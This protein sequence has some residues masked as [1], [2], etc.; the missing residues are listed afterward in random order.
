MSRKKSSEKHNIAFFTSSVYDQQYDINGDIVIIRSDFKTAK[1]KISS[2]KKHGYSVHFSVNL[3]WGDFSEYLNGKW[4]DINHWEDVQCDRFGKYVFHGPNIPYIIPTVSFNNYILSKLIPVLEYGVEAIHIEEPYFFVKSGY[5]PSFKKEWEM[6]FQKP[7]TP[8][9]N[10]INAQYE[11][12]IL[13]GELVYRSI[14]FLSMELKSYCKYHFNRD[15]KIYVQTRGYISNIQN[16]TIT[17]IKKITESKYIDGIVVNAD[18]IKQSNEIAAKKDEEIK[19]FESAFIE[20]NS[21]KECL[22][23]ASKEI[24]FA[25][26]FVAKSPL[27]SWEIN[28]SDYFSKLAAALFVPEV[29][30]YIICD[31]PENIYGG[32]TSKKPPAEYSMTIQNCSNFLA[33]KPYP[34]EEWEGTDDNPIGIFISDSVMNQQEYPADDIYG[35]INRNDINNFNY[36]YGLEHPFFSYGQKV[37]M[38]PIEHVISDSR[39]LNN[40]NVMILS[41]DFMKPENPSIHYA[42]NEWVRSG[43]VLIAAG[44]NNDSYNNLKSWWNTPPNNY[45]YPMRHLFDL[46]NV[47]EQVTEL[48]EKIKKTNQFKK[49]LSDGII[50]VGKGIFAY[51]PESPAKCMTD[52]RFSEYMRELLF[53]ACNKKK[54]KFISKAHY[55]LKKGP[56]RIVA[57]I[58]NG[59][60]TY[61]RS[62]VFADIASHKLAL[63]DKISLNEYPFLLVYD[64]DSKPDD[65]FDFIAATGKVKDLIINETE[66]SFKL[67]PFPGIP[68]YIRI[69][70]P[71]PNIVT[72]NNEEISPV[73]NETDK[74]TILLHFEATDKILQVKIRKKRI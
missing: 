71:Y 53:S 29:G 32:K 39:Y 40:Y 5:S 6:Y 13:K 62:G 48:C 59:Q 10:D 72:L 22:R 47:S 17:P 64:I 38:I 35:A 11:A 37:S 25:F 28:K 70:F 30:N 20:F 36:F 57:D 23:F 58:S 46:L 63:K 52:S 55:S 26:N 33:R 3:S 1:R 45:K 67:K 34:R 14:E 24:W 54:I 44:T 9:Y 74:R 8:I 19:L 4:D 49:V 61:E 68:G 41:Y 21:L 7:W 73:N 66:I 15:L 2:W 56:Y 42:I 69:Y 50:Q 31:C 65:D 27:A 60:T 51:F 12:S 16:K 18:S 43:G